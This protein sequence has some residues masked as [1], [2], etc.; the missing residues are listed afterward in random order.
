MGELDYNILSTLKL[1]GFE[2]NEIIT[3]NW[4]DAYRSPFSSPEESL[5]A[6]G[7]AVGVAT[8]SHQFEIPDPATKSALAE[9][10]A[11]AIW[12]EADR[13][14]HADHFLPLFKTAFPGGFV[15][16]LA[17]VGHYSPEDAPQV[18]ARLVELF[19]QLTHQNLPKL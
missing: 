12:G 15:Q 17:G 2:R 4:L 1:N 16:R 19:V 9:K 18:I 14:L 7:W 6:I 10:P 8:G 3:Q 13:T 5:G 11:L